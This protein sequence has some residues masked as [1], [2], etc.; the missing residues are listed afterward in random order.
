MTHL[1]TRQRGLALAA[2]IVALTALGACGAPA[3]QDP[4]T[5]NAVSAPRLEDVE[6]AADP[7]AF[8]GEVNVEVE[9]HIDPVDPGEQT[10]PVTL[11]DDQGTQV[12]VTDT[13]RVL[14]LDL[15][16]TLSRTVFELGMGDSLVGRDI[17]TQFDEA[18]DLPLVT[19]AG[20]HDLNAEALL[21]LEPTLI[22][23]D[24]SLG[25]WDVILQIRDA[26]VPVVVVDASRNLDNVAEVTH[27]VADALGVS[28]AG[29]ALAERTEAEIAD[30][31]ATIDALAPPANER[32]RTIFLYVRGSANVY[33]M[34]GQGSG[35]DDLIS[36]VGAYD[37]AGEIDWKGMRPVTSEGLIAA[38]PELVVMMTKGLE[39]TGGVDG[40]LE[41]VPALAQ[42]PAGQNRRFVTIEDALILGYGPSTA[43]VLNGL[44]VAV[45]A[46][47]ELA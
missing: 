26:G 31:R 43:E 8:S 17:S 44:A 39:S 1:R 30:V 18:T 6:V 7:R 23:T 3:E 21:E 45:L 2:L 34:F 41:K 46:P 40:L 11:T 10:L 25:P 12:H 38:A 32:L 15:Y 35:A 29:R 4:G 20:G 5:K 37:V 33:Y 16:G 36:A 28:E 24:T 47:E 9:D 14:A 22:I 19:S 42:T 13:S 27:M